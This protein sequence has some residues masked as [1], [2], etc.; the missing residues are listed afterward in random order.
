MN[1]ISGFIIAKNEEAKVE[2]ALQSLASF[3]DE[4]IFVDTGSTDK[5]KEIAA[6]YTNKIFDFKWIDDFSA[7]RNFALGK[8]TKAWIIYLDADDEIESDS[9]EKI[10]ELLKFQNKIGFFFTYK[11][12][13]QKDILT[14]RIFKRSPE[15]RFK[16]PIHEVLDIPPQLLDKFEIR[17]E[18]IIHH[19]KDETENESTLKRNI[20]ILEKALKKDL[21]NTHLEFFLGRE[22]FNTQKYAEAIAIFQ[23]LAQAKETTTPDNSF[24][25][26]LFLHLGFCYEKIKNYTQAIES[27]QKAHTIEPKFAEPLIY[28]ANLFLY[29]FKDPQ[30]AKNLYEEALQIPKPTT[31]FPVNPNFYHDFP[32]KQL[33]KIAQLEKPIA[34]ICGYYGQM[35]IG[36]ELMLAS[37]LQKFKAYRPIVASYNPQITQNLHQVESVQHHH[38]YFDQV[39]KMAQLVI[40]GGGTLFHD[41]GLIENKNV[42]YYCGIIKQAHELQK[43]I[44]LLGIGIDDIKLESNQKLIAEIFPFCQNISVRDRAS[45]QRLIDYGV[46]VEKI[47]VMP[48]LIFDLDPQ[49]FLSKEDTSSAKS[50]N[51]TKPP[52]PL[53]GINLCPPIIGSK[54]NVIKNIDELLVPFIKKHQKEY[55]FIFIP[56]K[57]DD[58]KLLSYLEEKLGFS[59]HS[60]SPKNIDFNNATAGK[61]YFAQ[62]LKTLNECDFIIASRY[63]LLLLGAMLNKNT[64]VLSYADKTDSLLKDFPDQIKIFHHF[65]IPF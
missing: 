30:K 36:D 5:T 13:S 55:D 65:D 52:R 32:K 40:I 50:Q 21:N 35:N 46:P 2:K 27:F 28:Q 51:Q 56:G 8:C 62:Y 1:N 34:L 42:E 3:C 37:L 15:L 16:M 53:V 25:Y 7:A 39:L 17:P 64:Y 11:Y 4:I 22:Y 54:N 38:P 44:I 12:N 47:Q 18:I 23:K 14:P 60:F 58:L 43:E 45:Q 31:T 6:K 41:Q 24:R 29:Q 10:K 9:Q 20:Q 59:L 26:N 49:Q 33:H 63:H 19:H 57:K 61:E 48:D